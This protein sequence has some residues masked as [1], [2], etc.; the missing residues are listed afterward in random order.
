MRTVLS[1]ILVVAGLAAPTCQVLCCRAHCCHLLVHPAECERAAN[2][3][4][5]TIGKLLL[6]AVALAAC[7]IPCR[8]RCVCFTLA[9]IW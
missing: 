3:L 8:G 5:L 4:V 6:R 1:R 9:C 7:A 2:L